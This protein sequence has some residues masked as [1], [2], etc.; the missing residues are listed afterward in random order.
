MGDVENEISRRY[1]RGSRREKEE[2]TLEVEDAVEVET[3]RRG[4]FFRGR[5]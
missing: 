5:R 4:R 3:E 2:D 1:I